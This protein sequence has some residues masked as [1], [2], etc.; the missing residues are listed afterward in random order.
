MTS[1]CDFQ[2]RSVH[3]DREGRGRMDGESRH[4]KGLR[5]LLTLKQEALEEESA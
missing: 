4:G 3:I 1:A 2:Q 5:G